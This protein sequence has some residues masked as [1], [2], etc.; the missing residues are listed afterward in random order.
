MT[1]YCPDVGYVGQFD[2]LVREQDRG[3]SIRN[4]RTIV[5]FDDGIVVCVVPVPGSP[6]PQL[7]PISGLILGRRY[8]QVAA[9]H[10]SAEQIRDAATA[11]GEA[12]RAHAFAQSWAEASALP[13]EVISRVVLRR[14][15]QISELV[16]EAE[17]SQPDR[18]ERLVFLG[19]VA[20]ATVRDM[21][22]PRLGDRLVVE[23]RD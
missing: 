7:G 5:V 8:G 15:R 11:A 6:G 19:D 4:T 9:K 16:I 14:P 1:G 18:P 17:S 20:E 21:L 3:H 22:A 10:R 2:N 12:G 23:A 13:F